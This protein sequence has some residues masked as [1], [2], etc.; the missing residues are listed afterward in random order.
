MFKHFGSPL[1][2]LAAAAVVLASTGPLWAKKPPKEEM[3]SLPFSCTVLGVLPGFQYSNAH[4]MNDHGD[5]VGRSWSD[6]ETPG[7]AYVNYAGDGGNRVMV[8]LNDL[9]DPNSG[10]ILI[11]ARGINNSGQISGFGTLGGENRAFR[12]TPG[13]TDQYD[14]E[15]PAVIE[16]LGTFAGNFSRARGINEYGDVTGF[17]RDA[18]G[19]RRAF[20]YSDRDLDGDGLPDSLV[21]IGDLGG[22]YSEGFC[23]NDLGQVGGASATAFFY[24]GGDPITHGFV[25]TP[26][27][28]MIDI[29]V[30]PALFDYGS[31]AESISN[32]GF[33]TGLAFFTVPFRRNK[34]TVRYHATRYDFLTNT[35]EDLGAPGEGVPFLGP[36]ESKGVAVNTPGDVLFS[37]S[38][39]L[40]L[41][42]R[43]TGLFKI[44]VVDGIAPSTA[45]D[46]NEAGEICG[47][48]ANQ[49]Y[50]LSPIVP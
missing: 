39:E 12:F 15:V 38:G 9:I 21:E 41:H 7:F 20:L 49:A 35:M 48:Q 42:F 27:Q 11:A 31:T 14:N 2:I 18:D 8:D 28:D 17:S 34:T 22:D 10:W 1:P 23:I 36:P 47:T 50:L 25:Y 30:P 13:Y 19:N 43:D 3:P 37:G 29:T 24:T 46:M 26:G 33:V 44:N 5:V 4:G 16:N 45:R 32:G 6:Q 40:Y